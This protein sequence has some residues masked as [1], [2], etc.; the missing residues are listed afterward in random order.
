MSDSNLKV[1]LVATGLNFPTSMSFLG[2]DDILVLEKNEGKVKRIVNG[3]IITTL[4]DVN[5]AD[6]EERGMSGIAISKYRDEKIGNERVYVFLYF[7][8]SKSTDGEDAT[9]QLPLGNRLYR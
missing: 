4:L 8:E 3:N 2:A 5:V 7:T 1:E 6:K 9:G